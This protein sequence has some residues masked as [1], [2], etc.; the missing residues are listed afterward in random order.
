M[1]RRRVLHEHRGRILETE[2]IAATLR[3][4]A[5]S[6]ES[7]EVGWQAIYS[8]EVV[9]AVR[10]VADTIAAAVRALGAVAMPG[11]AGAW[12]VRHLMGGVVVET[13]VVIGPAWSDPA[14]PAEPWVRNRFGDRFI[15]VATPLR[16][17]HGG[18]DPVGIGG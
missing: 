4:W 3:E 7:V 5:G 9:F 1:I 11:A 16:R 13:A 18:P 12:T 15:D 14:G 10:P 6:A 2:L 8:D 17:D